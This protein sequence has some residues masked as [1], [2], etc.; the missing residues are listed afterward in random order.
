MCEVSNSEFNNP[1]VRFG[2]ENFQEAMKVVSRADPS[3]I[4]WTKFK[5]MVFDVP[6]HR[7][8]YEDR[9]EA[10]GK[11]VLFKQACLPINYVVS[12][13]N[14]TPSKYVQIAEKVECHDVAHVEAFYQD[15]VDKGGEGVI[16][17]DP[18]APYQSGRCPGYLKHKVREGKSSLYLVL[19]Y[20]LFK[21]FRDAEA[22]IMAPAGLNQWECEM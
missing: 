22:K 2:K 14:N 13:L 19:I 5:Y 10:L 3:S 1:S 18:N 17:R 8:K 20:F 15:I 9:Y 4:D 7:G 11:L 12:K 16:L 6:D 21:K